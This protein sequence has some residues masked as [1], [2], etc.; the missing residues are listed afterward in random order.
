M[1][2]KILSLIVALMLIVSAACAQSLTDKYAPV[3]GKHYELNILSAQANPVENDAPLVQH[4]NELFDVTINIVNASGEALNV[5]IAAGDAP[6][7]LNVSGY[8]NY[9]KL[10]RDGV[11]LEMD[12]DVIKTYAPNYYE[13]ITAYAPDFFDSCKV[14]GAIYGFNGIN[15]WAPYHHPIVWNGQW[16]KAIGL[17]HAPET[18]EEMD[19]ALRAFANDDPDGNG[20]KD[21]F[22]LSTDG[23][24]LVYEAFGAIVPGDGI[25][26]QEMDGEIYPTLITENAKNALA[27]LAELYAEGI[28]SPDF[29]TGENTGGYWALSHAFINGQIGMT[30][31]AN[32]YHWGPGDPDRDYGGAGANWT[33]IYEV[34]PDM[35]MNIV[36]GQPVPTEDGWQYAQSQGSTYSYSYN[37]FN[38]D[39]ESE[40]DKV[41]KLLQIYDYIGATDAET[42]STAIYGF[43]GEQWD[44]TTA[45]GQNVPARHS[46]RT[47]F[48]DIA[49]G[50]NTTMF[51]LVAPQVYAEAYPENFLVTGMM[52]VDQQVLQTAVSIPLTA[53]NEFGD[54]CNTLKN[55]FYTQVIRGE[56]TVDDFD[57]FVSEW[58]ALGGQAIWDE[59]KEAYQK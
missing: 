4:W 32:H 31:K 7:T 12:E 46:D 3:E 30:C 45:W 33:A 23:M 53:Q 11:L 44:Y 36:Y 10:A 43:K 21:T 49:F 58:L 47:A 41:G 28:L 16:L 59:A 29:V 42:L 51:F 40:P 37:A 38:S 57:A 18:F 52:G 17:D 39:L 55:E 13:K 8:A 56:K 14:D 19:M 22:G 6:D 35:A 20:E 54:D 9:N 15:Y 50:G 48:D 1:T 2:R 25:F 26:W 27:Y 5:L 24:Q 34:D